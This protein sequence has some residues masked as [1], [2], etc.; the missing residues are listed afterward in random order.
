MAEAVIGTPRD[1]A[2]IPERGEPGVERNFPQRHDNPEIR[3]EFYLAFE[4]WPAIAQFAGSGL[5]FGWGAMGRRSDPGIAEFQP[6]AGVT[7]FRA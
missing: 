7:A 6:V 1:L 4:K 5:V 3:Q 2:A